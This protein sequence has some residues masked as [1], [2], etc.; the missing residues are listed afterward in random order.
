MGQNFRPL[1]KS[2][3]SK[4]TVRFIPYRYNKPIIVDKKLYIEPYYIEQSNSCNGGGSRKISKHYR[5]VTYKSVNK[6][7][8]NRSY[9]YFDNRTYSY[10]RKSNG[11]RFDYNYMTKETHKDVLIGSIYRF[12]GI[13]YRAI[14]IKYQEHET[15][16]IENLNDT[17]YRKY[18]NMAFLLRITYG[19]G[20]WC[21]K[22][23]R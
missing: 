19:Q 4:A 9:R 22:Y 12:N 18:I 23:R 17:E 5:T 15:N 8:T 16:N 1:D 20:S 7:R 11:Y 13:L 21:G 14:S 6:I 3:S 2:Y 10:K